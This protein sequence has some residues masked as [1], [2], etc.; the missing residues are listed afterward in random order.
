V[1]ASA[2]DAGTGTPPAPSAVV[3]SGTLQYWN[4]TGYTTLTAAQL[5]TAGAIPFAPL[6]VLD[7]VAGRQVRVLIEGTASRG[8]VATASTGSGT[9]IETAEATS[10]PPL[11]AV[12]TYTVLV[13]DGADDDGDGDA[14]EPEADD[15]AVQLTIV[16]DLGAA[17]VRATYEPA[18]TGS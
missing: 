15:L 8:G 3:S 10:G 13:A 18:P 11:D 7:T 9:S 4:G 14:E 16:V 6:D 2:G 1:S 12:L 17:E 5:Q